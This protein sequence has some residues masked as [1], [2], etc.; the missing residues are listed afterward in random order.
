VGSGGEPNREE[1]HQPVNTSISL[2]VDYEQQTNIQLTLAS[3]LLTLAMNVS[4]SFA[5]SIFPLQSSHDGDSGTHLY[6]AMT[7]RLGRAAMMARYFQLGSTLVRKG[8]VS[9]A[10]V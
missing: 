3:F 9:E 1:C 10:V 5:S 7:M 8:M 6:M 4:I 2:M